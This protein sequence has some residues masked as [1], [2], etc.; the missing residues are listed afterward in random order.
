[1]GEPGVVERRHQRTTPVHGSQ[2]LLEP[3]PLLTPQDAQEGRLVKALEALLAPRLPDRARLEAV[4]REAVRQLRM[5]GVAERE[6]TLRLLRRKGEVL[7][8]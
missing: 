1:M 7:H 3:D 8:A 5:L 4:V 6:A 2:R